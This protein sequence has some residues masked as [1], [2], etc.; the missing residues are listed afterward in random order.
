MKY[1]IFLLLLPLAAIAQID[2]DDEYEILNLILND[3]SE[4]P[5]FQNPQPF[6]LKEAVGNDFENNCISYYKNKIRAYKNFEERCNLGKGPV[7]DS[8]GMTF[9]CKMR[10]NYLKFLDLLNEKN[11]ENF[12]KWYFKSESLLINIADLDADFA[13]IVD[14]FPNWAENTTEINRTLTLNGP[15]YNETKD[16]AFMESIQGNIY[17]SSHSEAS[18]CILLI[19][20]NGTWKIAGYFSSSRL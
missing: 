5:F 8:L 17:P 12:D 10:E 11:I 13:V 18:N 15:F 7:I 3:Y 16:K 4:P 20:K 2:T 19:K 14:E 6:Y 9:A 1:I